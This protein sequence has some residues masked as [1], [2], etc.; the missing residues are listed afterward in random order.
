MASQ[1][2]Q[3]KRSTG[4]HK[5]NSKREQKDT[6]QDYW[7]TEFTQWWCDK[8]TPMPNVLLNVQFHPSDTEWWKQQTPPRHAILS[9]TCSRLP[10]WENTHSSWASTGTSEPKRH[11]K[12]SGANIHLYTCPLCRQVHQCCGLPGSSLWGWESS[13]ETCMWLPHIWNRGNCQQLSSSSSLLSASAE[14]SFCNCKYRGRSGL[15]NHSVH[16]RRL[17]FGVIITFDWKQ[18][19]ICIYIYFKCCIFHRFVLVK[20]CCCLCWTTGHY[21]GFWN[22]SVCEYWTISHRYQVRYNATWPCFFF[23]L[24]ITDNF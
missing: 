1:S 23:S 22:G 3:E 12:C 6:V 18:V 8:I 20:K 21:Y 11:V 13:E 5:S 17:L 24:F 4:D 7:C 16:P 19:I 9:W 14:A 2:K 10:N 15:L